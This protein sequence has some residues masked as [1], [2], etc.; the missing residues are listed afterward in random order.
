MPPV[1]VELSV[2]QGEYSTQWN[3]MMA[4]AVT[5]TVPMLIVYVLAQQ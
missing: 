2:F 3:L 5:A 1:T 4:A